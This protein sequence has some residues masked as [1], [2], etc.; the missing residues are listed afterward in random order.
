MNSSDLLNAVI[1]LQTR[2]AF[3]EDMVQSLNQIVAQQS[4]QLEQLQAKSRELEQA[5]LD[6]QDM[7]Q[8]GEIPQM[9]P[10]HY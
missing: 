7:A 1:D 10:P 2:F 4:Q 5:L 8:G 6:M 3:Q 9:P